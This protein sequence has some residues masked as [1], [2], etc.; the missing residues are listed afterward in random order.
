MHHL[1]N[2]F[3]GVTMGCLLLSGHVATA[4]KTGPYTL[5]QAG[6]LLGV[7][8]SDQLSSKG[9]L[10]GY[11]IHLVLGRNID[12][13]LDAGIGIGNDVYRGTTA[14]GNSSRLNLLPV[15]ADLRKQIVPVPGGRIGLMANAGYAPR[16]AGNFSKGFL[17][18][19]GLTYG[20]HLSYS[21]DLLFTAAYGLQ[22]LDTRSMAG[23]VIQQT[24]SLTV[25]LFL[26]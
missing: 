2:V 11:K 18:S 22:Q 19:G 23:A 10:P 9:V 26:Y 7:Q 20:H 1:F 15:Y 21:S 16:I 6:A 8:P 25:G 3:V 5:L 14:L 24:L 12:D 17:L 13:I 4:Q